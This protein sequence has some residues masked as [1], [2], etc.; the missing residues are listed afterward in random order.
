PHVGERSTCFAECLTDDPD[1]L[2]GLPLDVAG[3]E[4]GSVRRG[5][6]GPRDLDDVA[7][8][9]RP[10][11][12]DHRGPRTIRGNELPLA[13]GSRPRNSGSASRVMS[14]VRASSGLM[15]SWT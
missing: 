5:R 6:R 10:R 11:I 4:D 13:H 15:P 8:P 14:D 7:D 3:A 1:G 2:T 12:S 9:H